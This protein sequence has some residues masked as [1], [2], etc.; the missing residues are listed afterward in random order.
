MI[1]SQTLGTTLHP[2]S[3]G[4]RRIDTALA[5]VRAAARRRK[6]E[7]EIALLQ[8]HAQSQADLDVL[9]AVIN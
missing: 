7:P 3:P 9:I 1:T 8:D 2:V 5:L 4:G 6:E